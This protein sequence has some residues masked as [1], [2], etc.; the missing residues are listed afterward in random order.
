MTTTL[1]QIN[2]SLLTDHGQ[3]SSQLAER[4]VRTWRE[5]HPN[6][7][8]IHRDVAGEPVPH[9]DAAPARA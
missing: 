1:L 8:A 9:L 7:A 2:A 4:F 6:G 3:S 5:H